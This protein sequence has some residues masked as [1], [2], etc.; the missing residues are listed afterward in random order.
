MGLKGNG[1]NGNSEGTSSGVRLGVNGGLDL[2]ELLFDFS[3]D[4]HCDVLKFGMVSGSD[5]F[6]CLHFWN[7]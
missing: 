1:A 6:C 7:G 5:E 2:W 3:S 4:G